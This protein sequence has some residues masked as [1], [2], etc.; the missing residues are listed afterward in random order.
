ELQIAFSQ[1][2][3]DIVDFRSPGAAI[4]Q[5]YDAGSVPGRDDALEF[6]V[7]DWMVFHLHGEAFGGRVER[8][9]LRHGPRQPDDVLAE[10]EVVVQ[11]AGE[12]LLHAEE[13]W[14]APLRR[15]VL[16]VAARF[17]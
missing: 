13:S 10:A 17:G 12:M 1:R 15:A 14:L 7:L 3:I 11:V 5:D 2:R 16:A 4:P 6:A 8:R 9:S